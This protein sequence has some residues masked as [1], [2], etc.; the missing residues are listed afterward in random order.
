MPFKSMSQLRYLFAKHP[1]AARKFAAKTP[2]PAM[3][4]LPQKKTV[5]NVWENLRG[6]TSNRER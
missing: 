4:K 6:S 5:K 3:N 1:D 2:K